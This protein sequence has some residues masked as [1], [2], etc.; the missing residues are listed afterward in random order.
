MATSRAKKRLVVFGD[1]ASLK[2][3]S[4]G[5][6]VWNALFEYCGAKGKV[7]VI[8]PSY[9]NAEIG[10]SNGSLTEDEFY[11]TIAHIV[12]VRGNI[13]VVRNVPIKDVL[14]EEYKGDLRE[15]DS[16]IYAKNLFSPK[17]PIF[18][19]EFDGGEHYKDVNRMKSDKKK[20]K[21]CRA[22]GLRL[23]R[24]PNSYCKDYEFLKILIE[25]YSKDVSEGEQLTLF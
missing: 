20:A 22:K 7:D 3:M 15:F 23:I 19:F 10:K 18:A 8:P 2:K 9:E 1:Q 13:S 24:I 11:K 12:S 6:S 25:D 5:D 21:D 14:G 17:K 4:T 16:V